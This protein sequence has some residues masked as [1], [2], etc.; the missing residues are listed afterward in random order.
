MPLFTP[1]KHCLQCLKP[2]EEQSFFYLTHP[3]S[4]LCYRC[5]SQFNPI[6]E[7]RRIEGVKTLI[8]YP[9]DETIKALLYQLKGCG[10]YALAPV[11]LDRYHSLLK[12]KFYSFVV[13]PAPSYFE[14][15]NHRGFNHVEAI[16][17]SLGLTIMSIF[18]KTEKTKQSDLSSVE[19]QSVSSRIH[20]KS[21]V[22]LSNMNV[23]LVDDVLTT[24]ATLKAMIAL[25][26]PLQPKRIEIL[27]LSQTIFDKKKAQGR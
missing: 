16:F 15:D 21:T 5:F 6:F 2:I 20:I 3:G 13:I 27:V 22:D 17:S 7:S 25:V 1:T 11:F 10:D 9:Y 18:E 24:G 14:D 4:I 23:L 12:R 26:K 19:R 8:I